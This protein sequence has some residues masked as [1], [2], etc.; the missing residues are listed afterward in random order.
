MEQDV[1]HIEV[2]KTRIPKVGKAVKEVLSG[3]V[4]GS[5]K[6][7]KHLPYGAF[8]VGL[9]LVYIAIGYAAEDMVRQ[10]N[11]DKAELKEMRSEY[12]TIKSD[13][14]YA[15]KQSELVKLLEAKGFELEESLQPPKKIEVSQSELED[16]KAQAVSGE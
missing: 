10:I 15:T 3:E 13:L 5:E 11:R 7:L 8:L 14:M 16:Y 1:E 6:L 4:F 12:I 2:S 9:G